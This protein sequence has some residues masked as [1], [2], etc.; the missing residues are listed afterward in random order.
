MPCHTYLLML[1][2][3]PYP[4]CLHGQLFSRLFVFRSFS[5]SREFTVNKSV[6]SELSPPYFS[7]SYPKV[8]AVFIF[9]NDFSFWNFSNFLFLMRFSQLP[10]TN[11]FFLPKKV[12]FKFVWCFFVISRFVLLYIH[13]NYI[14]QFKINP[15]SYLFCLLHQ[16]F[17]AAPLKLY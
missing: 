15:D 17:K 6:L 2:T 14:A 8:G 13:A 12:G 5:D 3:L 9:F 16:V 10:K 4:R 11:K 1:Y 7:V